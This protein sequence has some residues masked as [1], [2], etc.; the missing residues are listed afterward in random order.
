[1]E[2]LNP[3]TAHVELLRSV[4]GSRL[5]DSNALLWM[6]LFHT[7]EIRI[8]SECIESEWRRCEADGMVVLHA[9]T[10][11]WVADVVAEVWK[12]KRKVSSDDPRG[13][14]GH[15]YWRYN[16]E[17]PYELA[18]QIPEHQMALLSELRERLSQDPCVVAV[19][20]ED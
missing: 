16:A 7:H 3:D 4:A 5:T 12:E 6:V 13:D 1:M 11:R 19:L 8:R 2:L 17:V 18:A 9:G 14:Y 20:P 15:W 10:Q